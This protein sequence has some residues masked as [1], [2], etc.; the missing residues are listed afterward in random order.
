MRILPVS[1]WLIALMSTCIDEKLPA[2]SVSPVPKQNSTFKNLIFAR[3][4]VCLSFEFFWLSRRCCETWEGKSGSLFAPSNCAFV[5][6]IFVVFEV[7]SV[8]V[9]SAAVQL[10]WA[11]LNLVHT[12]GL[13]TP[14]WRRPLVQALLASHGCT[15]LFSCHFITFTLTYLVLRPRFCGCISSL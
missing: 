1:M 3:G 14:F 6:C 8:S 7:L 12:R 10:F 5:N 13:A 9:R 4:S 15:Q 11:R 2:P